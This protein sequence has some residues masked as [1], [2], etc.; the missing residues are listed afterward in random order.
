M[1]LQHL[2][3]GL[4]NSPYL[5]S[6]HDGSNSPSKLRL[7]RKRTGPYVLCDYL[8]EVNNS[9]CLSLFRSF[10]RSKIKGRLIHLRVVSCYSSCRIA[11]VICIVLKDNTEGIDCAVTNS[12]S[13]GFYVIF[14]TAQG[15][16]AKCV[17]HRKLNRCESHKPR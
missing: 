14:A 1:F 8:A 7:S 5:P 13:G 4:K 9:T 10:Q 2:E 12:R 17:P 15:Q 3:L 16:P 6:L 11:H